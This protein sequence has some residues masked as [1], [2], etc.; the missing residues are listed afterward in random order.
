[1]ANALRCDRCGAYYMKT[2]KKFEVNKGKVLSY[3]ITFDNRD[4]RIG[5]HDLCDECAEKLYKFMKCEDIRSSKSRDNMLVTMGSRAAYMNSLGTINLPTDS[6]G[7]D[8]LAEFVTKAVD[9]YID[10][11]LDEPFD[12]YIEEALKYRFGNVGE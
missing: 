9:Q 7:E 12:L 5:C 3:V 11:D 8:E 6:S 10:E 4:N 2:D 1:M